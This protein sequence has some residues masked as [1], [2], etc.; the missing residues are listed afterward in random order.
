MR[1]FA[2]AASAINPVPASA[3]FRFVRKSPPVATA[4]GVVVAAPL[5]R[6][7]NVTTAPKSAGL[8][9]SE[10]NAGSP[11]SFAEKSAVDWFST[12]NAVTV[13]SSTRST[14][15]PASAP[16]VRISAASL[17]PNPALP[18]AV[19]KSVTRLARAT[20]VV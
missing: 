14:I 9:T 1:N 18:S 7:S 16:E 11:R 12:T 20:S 10:V 19:L 13:P 4:I 6:N 2:P 17:V 15:L 3:A 5:M 8:S